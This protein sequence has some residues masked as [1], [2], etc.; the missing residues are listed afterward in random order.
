[1]QKRWNIKPAS[2]PSKIEK[3]SGELNN[4]DA[5]LTN[6]L[7]QRE[8]D[9][10]D[11]AK[12]FFRPSLTE[13]HDPFLMQDM[14]KAVNRLALAIEQEQ[15][16]LVYGDYDVDGTTSVALVYSYLKN[17]YP[18]LA[19][20]IPDRYTEG[21][22]ISFQGID[23]AAENDF[24]LIIALDCGIKAVDKVAYAKEKGIDF[25]GKCKRI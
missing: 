3:L 18:H 4:L 7:L 24:K 16:I 6:I 21:Y 11:K 14:D 9:T 15:K 19:Y 12:T 23:Y 10:F 2:Q 20:Y 25:L 13:I 22:G 8:I 17:Y 1:M 5:T